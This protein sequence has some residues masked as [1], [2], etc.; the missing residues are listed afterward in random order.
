MNVFETHRK[1][2][3]DYSKFIR[4]FIS[5]SDPAIESNVDDILSE[6]K[7]W[8]Q[9]L[10]QFNPAY[11][12]AGP[13]D[14]FCESGLLHSDA[15]HIFKNYF[16]YK[17]QKEAIEL[18]S[19]NKDFVVTSGTGSG[20]SL[21]Y[22][23][24]IFNQILSSQRSNGVNG[25]IVYP[26]NALINSQSNELKTYRENY[27]LEMRR[28]FPILF[29]QY[30]GQEKEDERQIT[31]E[32]PPHILLTNYMMLELILTRA[33]EH[34]L[35]TAIFENLKFLVF[36]ELH[37]YRGRQGA[38]VAML[39]RRIRTHCKHKVCCIG[40]S[41]TMVSVDD[42]QERQE[43][44]ASVASKMFGRLFS[45]DQIVEETLTRSL[46]WKE[47]HRFSKQELSAAIEKPIDYEA[48]ESDF[49]KHPIAVWLESRIALEEKDGELIRRTP[50]RMNEVIHALV[51]ESNSS[52]N[53]CREA[54]ESLLHWV[55]L[56]NSR[57]M[58]SGSDS[59]IL[60]FKLHQF[61]AQTGSVYTSLDQDE[62]RFVTLD[63]GLYQPDSANKPIYPNVFSRTTGHPFICVTVVN[64]RLLPREFDEVRDDEENLEAG[65][66]IIGEDVWDPERDSESLP[67]AWFRYLKS[68]ERKLK[69]D[70]KVRMPRKIYFDEYGNFSNYEPM[71]Y[72]GWFMPR[73]LQ[74]DPTSGVIYGGNVGERTKLARLGFEGR[75]TSTTV[76]S[77][78][79]LNGL[80]E[81]GFPIKYQKLLSFTDSRQDAALQSGHFN[82]FSQV[83]RLRAAVYEALITEPD[84]FLDY[85]KLGRAIFDALSLPFLEFS[86]RSSDT[87]IEFVRKK[88]EESFKDFL[89][90][91]AFA[92]IRRSWRITLPNLEQCALLSFGYQD[93]DK[94]AS[95]HEFWAD[96]PF[97]G[98]LTTSDRIDFL[99]AVLEHFRLEFALHSEIYLEPRKINEFEKKFRED[100]KE[101]WTLEHDEK[102]PRPTVMYVD[103]I[104]SKFDLP[105]KS[106]GPMS[107]LGKYIRSFM[108][109]NELNTS[110][111]TTDKLREF[112]FQL[113]EKLVDADYLFTN[114]V[115]G[116]GNQRVTVFRLR[117]S[118]I[119]WKR[120]DGETVVPDRVNRISY[121]DQVIRPNYYFH[122]LYQ[123]D[124]SH[125]RKL[126]SADHTGQISVEDRQIR[127]DRF[128]A[129]W[130]LDP[131]KTKP[132]DAR[133]TEEG[134]SALF[135][136][137]TMELGIDIG[138]LSVVH[139]RNVP[140]NAANYV[141]R[142]GR[143]GRNGQGA[144]IFTFCSNFS[145]HD[146]HFF[147]NQEK[148]V[149][150]EIQAP[151]I[152]LCNQEL[153][154]TH[155]H[156]MVI[157]ETGF[158]GL[159]NETE[160][161]PS[162][163][164]I[165]DSSDIKLPLLPV[166]TSGFQFSQKTRESIKSKFNIAI[167]DFIDELHNR[168][169]GWYSADWLDNSFNSIAKR[170]DESM[171]RWRNLYRSARAQLSEATGAINTGLLK[172]NDREYRK[173]KRSQ[174]QANRQLTLLRNSQSGKSDLNEFYPY[175]YLAAEG[176]LPGYNFIRLP[177]RIFL[178]QG[179]E[180]G[181]YVSRSRSIALRE[182]GPL[183]VIYHNQRKFRVSQLMSN[184]DAS[185][186]AAKI[187]KKVGYFL[188]GK[189]SEFEI[190]P[191]SGANL[192]DGENSEYLNDLLEMAETRGE[193]T[194][195]ITCEDE[196]RMLKGYDIQPY[197]RVEKEIFSSVYNTTVKLED[198]E[199]LNLKFISAARL[200]SV[201]KSWRAR[202]FEGFPIGM[203]S[204]LW[205]NSLPN[206]D[207]ESEEEYR[208]VKLWTSKISDALY[209]E[210]IQAL[211]LKPDG[212]V[213]LQYALKRAIEI[214][215]QVE[216]NEIGVSIMGDPMCPNMLIY[217][218]VEGSLGVLSQF[219][220]DKN[221]FHKVIETAQQVCRFSEK[222]YTAPASYDDL[223][224]FYNQRDHQH[225]DRFLIESAL[226]K[227]SIA[228]VEVQDSPESRN[229][230][231]QYQYL[232][233]NLDPNSSTEV[234]FINHLYKNKL[235]LPDEAQKRVPG[236]YC[237]PDFYYEPRFWIFC[238]GTPHD[239]EEVRKRDAEQ[240]Q[241]IIN[242][243]DEVWAWN[244]KDDLADKIARRPDIFSKFR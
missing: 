107:A 65:Y 5:I 177:L 53:K 239:E 210:P 30:T 21:T 202:N 161:N 159:D 134:I 71:K 67:D 84:G 11:E 1:I 219:I 124:F 162:L 160:S 225:I 51:I 180:S 207:S 236:I 186:T 87:D 70:K 93:L 169:Q 82:D 38:D 183:N 75:S 144:L 178:P 140:P 189:Q 118:K 61:F 110:N 44:V 115:R 164:Q 223:L 166:V 154:T 20:K 103:R 72:W 185:I 9:P 50:M 13:I 228:R 224:S 111:I 76:N 221:I 105:T 163:M 79:I 62:S 17:H 120:G 52:E 182:F 145:A 94:I 147:Q 34:P 88:Y 211:S 130:Y 227:L 216:S 205:K 66:L 215:F 191:F 80:N 14:E 43:A 171:E 99:T 23:A 156:A 4:S 49:R 123:E 36:D 142:S 128:R 6:G 35:R 240:R 108:K 45:P 203:S 208:L 8:P 213:T 122:E 85:T 135:C 214:V 19:K 157:T 192:S 113:M 153:L 238:D 28:E 184:V 29:G 89:V 212:I 229:Y 175:R 176:F 126:V 187:S 109:K 232:L 218:D 196:E 188:A 241:L 64:N 33:R 204:G 39:I 234:V 59:T 173:Y 165:A 244:Y 40:T 197:F 91:R 226:E 55:S 174:D 46:E 152:E 231:E 32:S 12:K 125:R 58:T 195:R 78:S 73:R 102:L 127:E 200:I 24:T 230:D 92:D 100:L 155:L 132:D 3:E 133:I 26:M 220:E 86:N 16:L 54:I 168:S 141:Q 139:L 18:G 194:E 104:D 97:L 217:E 22:I 106:I 68:G 37:T 112:I 136:S 209:I 193:E 57:Q 170:L 25:V 31:R 117:I 56:I 242:R 42:Q 146:R 131:E 237:Q 143:A 63:P 101:P 201:N 179:A 95:A 116:I 198:S 83:V 47:G 74:F 149:A 222:S 148:M 119:L 81:E 233:Q 190:C 138:G 235:R 98:Q 48:E 90:F 181:N 15:R 151:K 27:E 199:L 7:L 121:K 137:P 158:P 172:I 2:V 129:D 96:L 150:G 167:D 41:A 69:S 10:L 243:G 60:P 77:Y 114:E 206:N